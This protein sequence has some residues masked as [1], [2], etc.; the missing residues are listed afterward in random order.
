MDKQRLEYRV[1]KMVETVLGGGKVEDDLVECKADWPNPERAARRIAGHA[2]AAHGTPIVWIL[3]VDE[4]GHKITP[5]SNQDP[6]QWWQQVQRRF[7]GVAPD[8]STL[9]VPV[10]NDQLVLALQFSTDR[11]PYL[12]KTAGA[13]G[14]DFEVPWREA[15]SVRSANRSNLL[16]ILLPTVDTPSAEMV[17]CDLHLSPELSDETREDPIEM[18][19]SIG[20]QIYFEAPTPVVLPAHRRKAKLD[21]LDTEAPSPELS[22]NFYHHSTGIMPGIKPSTREEPV[23]V[24]SGG[25]YVSGAGS[26]QVS[27]R[28][29]L[30]N[31]WL[32]AVM[33]CTRVLLSAKFP[34]AGSDQA[35]SVTAELAANHSDINTNH[36]LGRWTLIDQ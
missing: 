32:E 31:D 2:N 18:L 28:A 24:H 11:A 16:K 1:I 5:L 10:N 3:G 34:M 19:F 13:G 4:D 26:L 25:I 15:T 35:T 14:V 17:S 33:G 7:D 30:P 22:L 20:G 12:V 6:A 8:I 27:G 21:F 9:I 23:D 29:T 36:Y